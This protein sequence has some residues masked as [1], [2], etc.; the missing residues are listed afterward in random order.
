MLWVIVSAFVAIPVTLVVL[1]P[2][3][4]VVGN[5]WHWTGLGGGERWMRQMAREFPNQHK[6]RDPITGRLIRP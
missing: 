3:A 5:I 1:S 6:D 4:G 2:L